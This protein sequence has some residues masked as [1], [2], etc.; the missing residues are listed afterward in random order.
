MTNTA[1]LTGA[2]L[3][4]HGWPE[5]PLIGQ[6][7]RLAASLT[8]AGVS[9][10]DVRALLAQVRQPCAPV[11]RHHRDT[12]RAARALED[13]PSNHFRSSAAHVAIG[14]RFRR[15]R[16]AAFTVGKFSFMSWHGVR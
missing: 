14:P 4:E 12:P 11:A 15:K 3:I 5:G 13:G 1:P 10:D 7:L 8:A 2:E 16:D 6:A 9:A